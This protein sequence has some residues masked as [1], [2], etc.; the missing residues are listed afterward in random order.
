MVNVKHVSITR[1]SVTSSLYLPLKNAKTIIMKNN[2]FEFI[3]CF[4]RCLKNDTMHIYYKLISVYMNSVI[5]RFFV[6][7]YFIF[8]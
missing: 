8:S 1:I 7:R 4:V 5:T 3:I 2:D 6:P